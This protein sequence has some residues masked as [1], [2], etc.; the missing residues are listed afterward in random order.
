[1]YFD[2]ETGTH[3]NYFRDYDPALGRYLQSDPIGLAGGLN[4]YAYVGGNPVGA[5]DPLGLESP[6]GGGGIG[7]NPENATFDEVIGALGLTLAPLA[8]PVAGAAALGGGF[9]MAYQVLV[10]GKSLRCVNWGEVFTAAAAGALTQGVLSN[11]GKLSKGSMKASN[12]IRRYRRGNKVPPSHDVHHW[13]ISQNGRV[14]RSVPDGIKNHPM[15]LN[16]VSRGIHQRIHGKS[17]E[18]QFGPFGRWWHG[19]PPWAKSAEVSGAGAIL[20]PKGQGCGC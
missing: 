19:T 13:G 9:D 8:T 14:G 11:I 10:E 17:P 18:P 12:A 6:L 2:A 4:T 3:Y 15:N 20:A 16:P 7:A 1:Q 5:V